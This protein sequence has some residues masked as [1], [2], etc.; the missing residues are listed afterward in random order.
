MTIRTGLRLVGVA[1][2]GET[3]KALQLALADM[4]DIGLDVEVGEL[5]VLDGALSGKI[6]GGEIVFLDL[7]PSNER[8][9]A[10]LRRIVDENRGRSAIIATTQDVSTGTL[11]QLMRQG[12]DDCLPQP[13][14][15]S[16]IVDAIATARGKL[17]QGQGQRGTGKAIGVLRAKGGMGASTVALNLALELQRPHKRGE[18]GKEACLVDL[19]LQFGNLAAMLDLQP[20]QSLD[21]VI[22]TPSRLDGALLRN[23]AVRH[24]SGLHLLAAPPQPL[25]LETLRPETAGRLLEVAC[26]EFDHTVVDLPPAV[27]SW[28]EAVLLRLDLLV[29]VTQL[30]VPAIHQTKRLLDLL[31][32]E[33]LFGLPTMLVLNRHAWSFGGGGRI[34]EGEKA[35]GRKID[36]L[37]HDDPATALEACNRGVPIEEIA[38]RSR[39][40]RDLRALGDKA[41]AKL[42]ERRSS[43]KPALAAA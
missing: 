32:D 26:G 37:I 7:D 9:L 2:S 14:S 28:T 19:D 6:G 27:T 24:G 16:E 34:G 41:R 17:R 1:R 11:R 10:I 38:K 15:T 33:G 4:P 43:A 13:L 23:L 40:A 21:E 25:P 30:T 35:L 12:V 5:A 39:L 22:R 42:D 36:A 20:G 29:I 8:E 31:K 18:P 3:K